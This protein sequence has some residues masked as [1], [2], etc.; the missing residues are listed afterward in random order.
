M[1]GG[2]YVSFAKQDA[3]RHDD[4]A[5]AGNGY[6]ALFD[7]SGNL[8]SNPIAQGPLNSPWGMA[9]AP[10]G[11]GPF[12][13]ALLV[14][15][16]ADGKINAFSLPGGASLGA[17]NDT[18]GSPIA[19]P[20]LW[21]INF[22][23]G[24]RNEDAGTLY[25]TAGV[26]GGPNNDPVE[27]H[28]LLGSIQAAPS[29][30]TSGVQ[31]GASF[32]A[33][34]IAANEWVTIMGSGLSATTASWQVTGTQL[35]TQLNGVTVTVN[36]EAAPVSFLGNAQINFLVPA[37]I[38]PGSA[39]IQVKGATLSSSAISV[40]VQQ[41][42]PAFFTIGT[43]A[44]TGARYIAATHADGSLIGPASVIKGATPAK[45]GET[46]VLYGAGFGPASSTIPN[47]QA[48]SK[49]ITLPVN[50]LIIID[51]AVANVT[52]AGLTGTG[53]YQINVVVPSTAASADDLV[54][55]LIGNTESQAN[56]YLTIASQ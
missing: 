50:P 4:V 10:A 18:T 54:V 42:A 6:V 39:Q 25:F 28:G 2:V 45:P 29:F 7:M 52:F 41:M 35:P 46:I 8:L 43:N 31:N 33:G 55:A 30:T 38:Q 51:G 1:N 13:G 53:L 11:F 15:N 19:M 24:T 32:I 23:S 21:S 34:P 48:I 22:G 5:G 49:A 27:S 3:Q 47:G 44:T 12:A 56:A 20:G 37:D 36:G 14:G 40:N 16:F 9:I 17:L 26:G